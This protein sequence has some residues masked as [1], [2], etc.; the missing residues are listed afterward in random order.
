MTSRLRHK[1]GTRIL[2]FLCMTR[3][4]MPR[5]RKDCRAICSAAFRIC[6]G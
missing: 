5:T 2:A 6:R 4:E 1:S 3:D